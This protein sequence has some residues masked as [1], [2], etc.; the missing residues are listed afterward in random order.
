MIYPIVDCPSREPIVVDIYSI[1]D[2]YEVTNPGI[3][4]AVKKL[5]CGG[6]RGKGDRLQDY[7]EAIDAVSR[8]IEIEEQ[9][10]GV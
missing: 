2:A 10:G 8:A 6:L 1:L 7:R 3:Q 5:L 4:H 9:R